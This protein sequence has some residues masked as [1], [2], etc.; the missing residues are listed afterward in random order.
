MKPFEQW[1]GRHGL[2]CRTEVTVPT[3]VALVTCFTAAGIAPAYACCN[4]IPGTTQSFRASQTTIDRPFAGPGDFVELTLDP[5]CSPVAR[6]FSLQPA[7]QVITVVFTPPHGALRNVI[8]L[9][10][11]CAAI[12][13]ALAQC[14]ASAGVSP[15]CLPLS[16]AASDVQVIDPHTLRFRFP[17]TS[18]FLDS[19]TGLTFT[20]SATLAVTASGD[21]LPCNLARQPCSAQPG[22]LACVDDLFATDGTCGSTPHPVFGHFTALPFANDYQALCTGPTVTCTGRTRALQLTVDANGNVLLPM[23]WSGVLVHLAGAQDAVPVPRTVRASLLAEAFRGTDVPIGIPDDAILGSF[24]P[25]GRKL[26]PIFTPVHDPTAADEVTLF[27]S[28]D[29]PR[30]VLR[31]ARLSCVGG[32]QNGNPCSAPLDCPGGVCGP[33]RCVGGNNGGQPCTQDTDC[34]GGS[35][36]QGLFDLST[37]LFNGVGPVVLPLGT[38]VG[39]AIAGKPCTDDASCSGGQCQVRVAALDPVPLDGLIDT[40]Q[41][42]AFV[43]EEAIE[44]QDLNGDA[45]MTDHVVTLADRMTGLTGPIGQDGSTGRAVARISQPPFSFPAVAVEGDV[46]AFLEPEPAQGNNDE[47]HNGTVFD[48]ILRVFQLV[49]GSLPRAVEL[50]ND[51]NPLTADAA[52][53]INGRSLTVSNGR[54][55]FRTNEA[56]VARQI[57]TRMSV[58]TDGTQGSGDTSSISANGRFVVFD[59]G[60]SNLVEGD[61][62]T[63]QTTCNFITPGCCFDVFIHDRLSGVTER[64]SVASDGTQGD[65]ASFAGSVSADGSIVAFESDATNLVSSDTNGSRDIFVHNRLTGVTERVSVATDGTEANGFSYRPS[66]SAD[67]RFVAFESNATNLVSGDTNDVYDVFVHDRVTGVTE[68]MS[69]A[70][71]GAEGNAF[72]VNS[73]ISA[74]GRYVVFESIASNL[75]SGLTGGGENVFVHDR[76]T[77]MT[78]LASVASDGSQGN[79]FSSNATLSADGR[80]V[81]FSSGASD[82]VSG[83]TNDNVDVFVHDR[84]RGVTER[85]ST[86]S[87]GTQGDDASGEPSI[88]ADGRYV[89]FSSNASNLVA[90]DTNICGHFYSPGGCTDVFIHDRLTGATKRAS[91]ASDGSQGNSASSRPSISADGQFVVFDSGA[92][93]LVSGDTNGIPDVFVRGP[94]PTDRSADVSG[95]G[96]LD[97]TV[98][99]LLDTSSGQVVTFGPADQAVVIGDTAAFLRPEAAAPG[100]RRRIGRDGNMVGET[101]FLSRVAGTPED[102]GKTAVGVALS[103]TCAGGVSD[104]QACSADQD[105]GGAPGVQCLASWLAALVP[106]KTHNHASVEVHRVSDS[107]DAWK[108]A[109]RAADV[110]DVSGSIVAFITPEAA[111]GVDLNGDGDTADRILQ[112]YDAALGE[113]IPVVDAQGRQQPAEEFVLGRDL[114]AF[115][116]HEAALCGVPVDASTCRTP[117]PGCNCDLNGDGDCC[118]D[119]LQVYDI[120]NRRLLN[121][122]QAVTPCPLE[123]CDPRVPYRVQ[124]DTV[125]FITFECDQSNEHLQ[126]PGCPAPGPGGSDLDGDGNADGLVLQVFNIRMAEQT[127]AL[128]DCPRTDVSSGVVHAGCVTAVAG[129][130]TG[131]CTKSGRACA[132]PGGGSK[133]PASCGS[134]FVPPGGCISEALGGCNPSD[135]PTGCASGQFCE[136]IVGQPQVGACHML[137]GPCQGPADCQSLDILATCNTGNQ[138]FQRLVAPLVKRN[139]GA[140]VLTGA[141]RCVEDFGTPCQITAD[142]PRGQFC[143][144]G[145]TCQREHGTCRVDS[146]CPAGSCRAELIAA[147]AEDSDGD[148][149][150][151]A[152]DNCPFVP[153]PDQ[154]DSDHDGVGDACD[155]KAQACVRAAT[156]PSLHCRVMAL[157][158][159]TTAS[160]SPGSFRDA[161]LR[162]LSHVDGALTQAEQPDIQGGALRRARRSLIHYSHRLGSQAGLQQVDAMTRSRLLGLVGQIRDDILAILRSGS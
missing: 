122:G 12:A 1:I 103:G 144:A 47:N 157:K 62:N 54:V 33:V 18:P 82:L 48:T 2:A 57:T 50:T 63:C 52:P 29:T 7:D 138:N 60:A 150:P 156:L 83:D 120:K 3:L 94:D 126:D 114:V 155:L 146:D 109:G 133:T 152:F 72:S 110:V 127:T 87:D 64:V 160:L 136:P 5:T 96:N 143:G 162:A 51:G 31:V 95:D 4:V 8:V 46:L 61:T 66:L 73:S 49:S 105:C 101:V 129:T 102:L 14:A 17:D 113:P 99:R 77:G 30:S 145:A 158:S 86:A 69:V 124:N 10:V 88:S 131:I 25:D 43:E 111:L 119:V 13:P 65:D 36:Q 125:T 161:L 128:S 55:F 121:T 81:A 11:D 106:A 132:S 20:G 85:V 100:G 24:S 154:L 149:I 80:Y 23:D 19:T 90:D 137:L 104:G 75:V 107:S 142:C 151:D 134:C 70:S 68:R 97:E 148:E 39:G 16:V 6:E 112:L 115:R 140:K 27:G 141:G 123:A 139:G 118:D 93:N 153:N 35:C 108:K 22:L 135:V 34:G 79:S 89:A 42:F 159:A 37:Q 78:E 74:D 71:D 44:G 15:Q 41:E 76:L 147:T 21:A 67:G 117:P 98:L 38:C 58:A 59:S 92:S 116:T 56:A 45:D 130:S 84:L 26:P 9:A 40:A 28:T 32:A 91:V 53:V